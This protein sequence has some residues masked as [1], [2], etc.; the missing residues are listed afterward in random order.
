MP[1][2]KD[3]ERATYCRQEASACAQAAL[4]TV[5]I[6]IKQAYLDLEQGW[7]SLAPKVVENTD[8]ATDPKTPHDADPKPS[9]APNVNDRS[10]RD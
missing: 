7:L 3:A 5:I 4:T 10:R 1:R 2:Y 9:R 8:A 6:E